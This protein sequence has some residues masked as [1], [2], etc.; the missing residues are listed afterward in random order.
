MTQVDLRGVQMTVQVLRVVGSQDGCTMLFKAPLQAIKVFMKEDLWA[1]LE[2]TLQQYTKQ[3]VTAL[4]FAKRELDSEYSADLFRVIADVQ[5][6]YKGNQQKLQEALMT[7]CENLDLIG[8]LGVKQYLN[9]RNS[10]FMEEVLRNGVKV[11]LLS[12]Q[13]EYETIIKVNATDFLSNCQHTH[14]VKGQSER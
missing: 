6:L 7:Q 8:I 1:R 11:W 10:M 12:S 2:D 9:Y 13:L 4:T 14:N 5:T 3:G